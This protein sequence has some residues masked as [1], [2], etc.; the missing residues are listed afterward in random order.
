[1]KPIT[2]LPPPHRSVSEAVWLYFRL[3]RGSLRYNRNC[4]TALPTHQRLRLHFTYLQLYWCK[5][6]E[7]QTAVGLEA[8]HFCPREQFELIALVTRKAR[9][10]L[11]RGV[12]P[13]GETADKW[14]EYLELLNSLS[15][16]LNPY[17]FA[18]RCSRCLKLLEHINRPRGGEGEPIK[19][20]TSHFFRLAGASVPA[21][22][23]KL[24]GVN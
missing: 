1:M 11:R 20:D 18:E 17:E 14:D 3:W 13:F 10:D 9:R 15:Y 23:L 12:L 4:P 16:E 19:M 5:V 6:V 2:I 22:G 24:A 21:G 8:A 7:F